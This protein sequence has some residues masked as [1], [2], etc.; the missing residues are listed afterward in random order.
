[1][2]ALRK[3]LPQVRV[4]EVYGWKR[5]GDDSLLLFME[6]IQGDPLYNRW[7]NLTELEKTQICIELDAMV[8]AS[9][10]LVRPPKDE[11]IGK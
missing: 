2:W 5:D 4:P 9:R 8:R 10:R 6:L 7:K 1:M 3:F 11:S